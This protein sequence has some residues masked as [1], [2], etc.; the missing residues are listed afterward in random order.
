MLFPTCPSVERCSSLRP[1]PRPTLCLPI[2]VLAIYPR[3][4]LRSGREAGAL[5]VLTASLRFQGG[6][7]QQSERQR[8]PGGGGVLGGRERRRRG[9]E[10]RR[11]TGR[12]GVLRHPRSAALIL[13]R[14][15]L[16]SAHRR[17]QGG[18]A[19]R[20]SG[21][22]ACRCL[23][24]FRGCRRRLVSCSSGAALVCSFDSN[25]SRFAFQC[26]QICARDS[27]KGAMRGRGRARTGVVNR[28]PP[29]GRGRYS[30]YVAQGTQVITQAASRGILLVE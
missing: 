30:P 18:V 7:R 11:R 22:G 3:H 2:V 24:R 19:V 17:A 16:R 23:R 14:S 5:A 27:R 6:L 25:K 21:G 4:T 26:I 10:T 20:T 1:P 29:S 28:T 9:H 12:G 13:G 15:V 8:G